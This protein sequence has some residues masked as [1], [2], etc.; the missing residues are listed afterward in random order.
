MEHL[1]WAAGRSVEPKSH[2]K[3]L[4]ARDPTSVT[5]N[6]LLLAVA[7]TVKRLI[8]SATDG[9]WAKKR[10]TEP[11][12]LSL[13]HRYNPLALFLSHGP[14]VSK[15]RTKQLSETA[16]GQH[17]G[18]SVGIFTA[19]QWTE[20]LKAEELFLQTPLAL[21]SNAVVSTLMLMD[22]T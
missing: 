7:D 22:F 2:N 6:S 15:K 19:P 11:A 5:P 9:C 21:M 12:C 18:L 8:C 3:T 20:P 1:N 13:K 14:S 4:P 16:F 17:F 10:T